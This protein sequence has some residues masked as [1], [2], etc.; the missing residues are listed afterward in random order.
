MM[1]NAWQYRF[2]A[3]TKEGSLLYF[4]T[5]NAD[6]EFDISKARGRLDLKSV[7]YDYSIDPIEGAPTNYS[8]QIGIPNEEKWKLCADTKEIQAKWC[9]VLDKFMVDKVVSK[10]IKVS[11][12]VIEDEPQRKSFT[13][14][15]PTHTIVTTPKELEN[16]ALG[17]VTVDHKILQAVSI[18]NSDLPQ[19]VET[20]EVIPPAKI[21]TT[22]SAIQ[23][24]IVN[25]MENFVPQPKSQSHPKKRLKLAAK[26]NIIEQEWIEWCLVVLVVNISILGV[27]T[28]HN[29]LLKIVYIGCCNYVIGYTLNLRFLR[30]AKC[31]AHVTV[32]GAQTDPGIQQFTAVAL[33]DAVSVGKN[34]TTEE[35]NN[36]IN[37]EPLVE[38]TSDET[39]GSTVVRGQVPVAGKLL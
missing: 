5:E 34:P 37:A 30:T 9:K 23:Q 11:T 2:V 32:V 8:I 21:E 6:A 12:P 16:N 13:P 22:G 1:P 3:I 24:P 35:K 19:N 25:S 33:S 27:C 18:V 29:I 17:A 4:D 28:A 31:S 10:S 14:T 38:N 26:K 7:P 15:S 20:V 39:S 36:V